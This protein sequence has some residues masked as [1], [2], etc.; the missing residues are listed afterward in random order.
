[1]NRDAEWGNLSRFV[2]Q[3]VIDSMNTL[4]G[5]EFGRQKAMKIFRG[6][7]PADSMAEAR[8]GTMVRQQPF[9]TCLKVALPSGTDEQTLG[10]DLEQFF[11]LIFYTDLN[12]LGHLNA[13]PND[14]EYQNQGSLHSTST[15]PNA[16]V[17]IEEAW[18]IETGSDDVKVG[19]F[20]TGIE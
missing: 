19:V 13:V 2:K 7:T 3:E 12:V 1:N 9:W 10:M 5:F 11:P 6:L 4:V 18:E 8:D 17:N 20:D 16:H 15:F 14:A